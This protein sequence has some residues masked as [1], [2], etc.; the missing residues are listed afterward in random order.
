MMKKTIIALAILGVFSTTDSHGAFYNPGWSARAEGMGGVFCAS[1]GDA[2]SL[3]YNPAAI[4]GL[5][6]PEFVLMGFKPYMSLSGVEWKYYQFSAVYPKDSFTMGMAYS[7]FNAQSLYFENSLLLSGAFSRGS[8]DIGGSLKYLSHS[9]NLPHEMQ[10][11]FDSN[12]ASGFSA[13]MG[14]VFKLNGTFSAGLSA[15]NIIPVDLGIKYED[16]VPSIYRM[17]FSAKAPELGFFQNVLTGMDLIYRSQDWGDKL[18][19]GLGAEAWFADKTLA[20]RCGYS[21]TA[22]NMGASFVVEDRSVGLDYSFSLPLEIQDNSGSHR[23]QMVFR[24]SP[25]REQVLPKN[26]DGIKVPVRRSDAVP[27]LKSED[28]YPEDVKPAVS[29]PAPV[30]F[31]RV[32]TRPDDTAPV[33]EKISE[34]YPD[35]IVPAV[36]DPAPAAIKKAQPPTKKAGATD[37][38]ETT[39]DMDAEIKRMEE[40]ILGAPAPPPPSAPARMTPAEKAKAGAHFNKATELYKQGRYE[41]AIAEWQEVLKINPDHKLSKQKIN[42]AQSLIDTK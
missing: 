34:I 37:E 9:Y 24:F 17:G 25:P 40:E 33:A 22:L 18:S 30:P 15:E 14:A 36:P 3:F 38:A 2:S 11:F 41:E 12:S 1:G 21:V 29:K 23:I 28:A 32:E 6:S 39:S 35:D 26:M 4:R 20:V 8:A 27:D 42:K 13:D 19:W 31:E 5:D 10:P 7:G 16:E